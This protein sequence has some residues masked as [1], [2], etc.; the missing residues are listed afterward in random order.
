MEATNMTRN[1][2]GQF[3]PTDKPI[4]TIT[5][6]VTKDGCLTSSYYVLNMEGREIGADSRDRL[7]RY[8]R[9]NGYKVVNQ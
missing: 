5:Q 2:Q 8:A 3:E 6:T 7:A 4:A 1:Q 9:S